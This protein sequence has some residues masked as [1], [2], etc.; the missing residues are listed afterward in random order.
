M[1]TATRI[2]APY[3]IINHLPFTVFV[4]VSDWKEKRFI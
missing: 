1:T 3:L 4:N 2:I